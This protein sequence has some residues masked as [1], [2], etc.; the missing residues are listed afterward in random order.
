MQFECI[1]YDIEHKYMF[2]ICLCLC[3]GVVCITESGI[4]LDRQY[5]VHILLYGKRYVTFRNPR[6]Y[7]GW[8]G[9]PSIS[10]KSASR[11]PWVVH[12]GG[13]PLHGELVQLNI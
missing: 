3:D 6:S 1:I 5:T 8:F 13:N 2:L 11:I 7:T 10:K 9:F 12:C 4:E